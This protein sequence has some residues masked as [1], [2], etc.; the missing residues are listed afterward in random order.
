MLHLTRPLELIVSGSAIAATAAG[1]VLAAHPP[2]AQEVTVWVGIAG[3]CVTICLG[4]A[5]LGSKAWDARKARI[6][7]A[8]ELAAKRKAEAEALLK[9]AVAEEIGAT[10]RQAHEAAFADLATLQALNEHEVKDDDRDAKADAR[11]D[12]LESGQ[13]RMEEKLDNLTL[14]LIDGAARR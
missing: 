11:F 4:L 13:R 2:T 8:A 9:K 10:F 7:E 1:A 12:R 5:T 3:G 6:A 14:H